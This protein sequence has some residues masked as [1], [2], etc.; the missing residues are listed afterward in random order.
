MKEKRILKLQQEPTKTVLLAPNPF[1]DDSLPPLQGM[2]V[3]KDFRKVFVA[4]RG[5]GVKFTNQV[6]HG[7]IEDELYPEFWI[8]C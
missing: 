7:L 4:M 2:E 3:V 6:Y 8:S 1:V 5:V